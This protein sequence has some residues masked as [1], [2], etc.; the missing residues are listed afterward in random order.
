M[1]MASPDDF[2]FNP[3]SPHEPLRPEPSLESLV[4]ASADINQAVQLKIVRLLRG[5][6]EPRRRRPFDDVHW[7]KDLERA[8]ISLE[9]S[10]DWLKACK[11]QVAADEDAE[12]RDGPARPPTAAATS[13]VAKAAGKAKAAAEMEHKQA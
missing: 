1:G 12:P 2:M 9:V 4:A 13:K 7:D 3:C 10:A 6:Q 11:E 8:R 5:M